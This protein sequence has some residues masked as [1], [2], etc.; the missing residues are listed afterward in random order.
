[1]VLNQYE[2]ETRLQISMMRY[3]LSPQD[4]S[5]KLPAPITGLQNVEIQSNSQKDLKLV[6]KILIQRCG[7]QFV[8]VWRSMSLKAESF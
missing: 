7:D 4:W 6:G 1:M 5:L 2:I 3:G 8:A